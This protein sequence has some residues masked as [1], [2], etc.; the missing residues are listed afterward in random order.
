MIVY[1]NV[2][3]YIKSKLAAW[4]DVEP[5]EESDKMRFD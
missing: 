2:I 5:K 4:V 3:V 1:D